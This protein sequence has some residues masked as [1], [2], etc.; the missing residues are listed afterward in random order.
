MDTAIPTTGPL[1][2]LVDDAIVRLEKW[3]S[4][5]SAEV[6]SGDVV[7]RGRLVCDYA[8][9]V[10]S[11]INSERRGRETRLFN[12][13][14]KLAEVRGS[15]AARHLTLR[16]LRAEEESFRSHVTKWEGVYSPEVERLEHLLERGAAA[17]MRRAWEA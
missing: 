14:E 13:A 2:D 9:I 17:L 3:I 6:I 16:D 1:F 15:V 8:G 7:R 5:A 11:K 4:D 10:R 12:A